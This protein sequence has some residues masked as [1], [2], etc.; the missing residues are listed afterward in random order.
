MKIK[1]ARENR[2][3]DMRV[4]GRAR[5]KI[6]LPKRE[7]LFKGPSGIPLSAY[8]EEIRKGITLEIPAGKF[9]D[10]E[11]HFLFCYR[12]ID[13][14]RENFVLSARF[15][16]LETGNGNWQ[17]GYGI[18]A[19]DTVSVEKFLSVWRNHLLVGRCRT[20]NAGRI[21]CGMRIAAG[22]KSQMGLPEPGR[23]VLDLSRALLPFREG[24]HIREGESI[25][26]E[27][28]KTDQG[29]IG[30]VFREGEQGEVFLPGCDFLCEQ[31]LGKIYVGF[32]A[33][34]GLKVRVEQ[35]RFRK[36]PGAYSKC[37]EGSIRMCLPD[38]P[39][40]PSRIREPEDP[41]EGL[42]DGT[43]VVSPSGDPRGEGS[44][45]SPMSLPEA[46]RLAGPGCEIL[47]EDG[48]YPL[49]E[50]VYINKEKSGKEEARI[51]LAARHPGKA[52]LDASGIG[53]GLP[54]VILRGD[55]WTLEGLVVR[56]APSA[57]IHVAGSC[58]EILR[59]ETK[60]NR[61]TGLLITAYPGAEKDEYPAYNLIRDCESH[62]NEDEAGQNADG[63]GAKLRIGK[64]NRFLRCTAHHNVD[65]GFDLYCKRVAG[66][67]EGV[68]LEDC[69]A[70]RNGPFASG[71]G[72]EIRTGRGCGFKLG[73]E[74]QPVH[75][76][77]RRSAAFFNDYAG[78]TNNS[79]PVV[80]LEDLRAWQNGKARGADYEL[81]TRDE[82]DAADWILFGLQPESGVHIVYR[83]QTISLEEYRRLKE[84][85]GL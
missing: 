67:M 72:R 12:E 14:R 69:T 2:E 56:G 62:H 82:E 18:M 83:G 8:D 20:R 54:G 47:L 33:A 32:A 63:F 30:R 53:P 58:N 38:Y 51:R 55:F 36:S 77:V 48:D 17:S 85:R 52:V 3:W 6:L 29:F 71:C 28:E 24:D 76:I 44:M 65:D 16:V 4:F 59:C 60:E 31:D 25:V 5:G 43:I 22:H 34:G 80:E 21:D 78:F 68:L 75:H 23:R 26:L 61:D 49:R 10:S 15:T 41:A 1:I 81:S 46:V 50:P 9:G 40:D 27:L 70:F 64:G 79:N 7:V 13:P 19:V 39:F 11:D 57:G 42:R 37:P 73:G 84:E 45:T 35:A 66:S 74:S